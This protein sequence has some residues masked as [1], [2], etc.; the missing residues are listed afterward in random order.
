MSKT[1]SAN[2]ELI[3]TIRDLTRVFLASNPELTSKSEI[4]RKLD[5]VSI[6]P[7]R[8][9]LLLSMKVKDV[10][11]V[12]SKAKKTNKKRSGSGLNMGQGS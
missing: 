11:S 7:S 5:S 3:E 12:L 4:I 6:P 9:S 8:I 10:T 1:L 2:D